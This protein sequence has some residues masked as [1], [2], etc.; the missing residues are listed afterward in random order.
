M[1]MKYLNGHKLG[2]D[3]RGRLEYKKLTR[4]PSLMVEHSCGGAS[5]TNLAAHWEARESNFCAD[6]HK[7]FSIL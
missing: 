4:E 2:T 1:N 7:H 5:E 6:S 3:S